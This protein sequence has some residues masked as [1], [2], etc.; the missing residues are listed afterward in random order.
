L[1]S[2]LNEVISKLANEFT[3]S[4]VSSACELFLRFITR[5]K[6]LDDRD[7]QKCK[8]VLIERGQLFFQKAADARKKIS[9]LGGQFI[10]D[11]AT[12]LTHSKSMVVL[13]LLK[14]AVEHSKR[15]QVY[16]TESMPN[17]S[18]E[19]MRKELADLGIPSTVIL[20]SAVGYIMERVDMVLVGAEK[21]V[22]SGG[23][24]NKIGTYQLAVMAKAMN[25]PVY[26]VAESFKF[27][28]IY[29]LNQREVPNK[30]KYDLLSEEGHPLIDYTPPSYITLLFTEIGILTPSAVSDELINLYC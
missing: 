3:V 12:I 21:V 30:N 8:R 9:K 7:F 25:K 5:A 15:F 24:I 18:G 6:S 19:L 27:E 29:P 13:H 11:G 28:R 16:I 26:A 14:E 23:L 1:L 20:D 10:R 4:S 22:E 17:K 2:C